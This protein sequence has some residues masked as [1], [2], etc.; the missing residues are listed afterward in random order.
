MEQLRG[1]VLIASVVL[2]IVGLVYMLK[3]VKTVAGVQYE[4]DLK[5]KKAGKI[6]TIVASAALASVG[7]LYAYERYGK[8]SAPKSA[9]LR[10]YYF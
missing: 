6:M 10:Y 3:K 2:L 1:Y 9:R 4:K 7:A 8:K 5:L